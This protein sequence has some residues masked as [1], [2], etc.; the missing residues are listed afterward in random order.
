MQ[1]I[2]ATWD[3]MFAIVNGNLNQVNDVNK[4]AACDRKNGKAHSKF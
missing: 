3:W 4:A 2:W 1:I